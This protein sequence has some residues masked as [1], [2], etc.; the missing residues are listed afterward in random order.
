MNA[1]PTPRPRRTKLRRR[2][3]RIAALPFLAF[4]RWFFPPIYCLYMKF[5]YLTSSVEHI[6]T[7]LLW[8]LRKRYGGLVGTMWHEE[9]FMVAWSFRQYEG[10]TL[11]SQSDFGDIIAAML[12]WNKFVVLRGGSHRGRVRRKILPQMIQHMREGQG[13]AYGITCDGSKGPAYVLKNGSVRIAHACNKPMM[14]ARTW[15]KRRITLSGWD[16]AII[17]LPFNRIVQTFVGPYFPPADADDPE[18]L[19]TFRAHLEQELLD[20]TWWT[21][22]RMGTLPA[23]PR[24]GFPPGW[25]PSWGKTL[26]QYPFAPPSG[27]PA[28]AELGAVPRG[29]GAQRR[30]AAAIE[31]WNTRHVS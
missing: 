29:A 28:F 5:V 22:E 8:A 19:E 25:S 30:Q 1:D 24:H 2:L 21:H 11:A 20:L 3:K 23:E 18:V 27:H 9:V 4:A 16:R 7:D 6:Q 26:P 14:V 15:C 12:K 17:P 13:V 31:R 10:H